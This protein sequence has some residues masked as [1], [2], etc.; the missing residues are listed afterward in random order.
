MKVEYKLNPKLTENEFIDILN[1][2]ILGERRPI[3]DEECIGGMLLI[4]PLRR[5]NEK[6]SKIGAE[7]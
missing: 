3:D 1:R 7:I 6:V 2:S 5:W 4:P